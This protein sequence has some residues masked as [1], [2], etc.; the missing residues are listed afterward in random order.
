MAE[1][2]STV[3]DEEVDKNLNVLIEC[4]YAS[5]SV[6]WVFSTAPKLEPTVMSAFTSFAGLGRYV[7][8]GFGHM[9]ELEPPV[10]CTRGVSL[11]SSSADPSQIRHG[12]QQ[13]RYAVPKLLESLKTASREFDWPLIPVI[14]PLLVT[15]APLYVLNSAVTVSTVERAES[16][17]EIGTEHKHLSIYQKAGPELRAVC[18]ISAQAMVAESH[19]PDRQEA[20][21]ELTEELISAVESVTIVS[22]SYL[23]TYLGNLRRVIGKLDVATREQVAREFASLRDADD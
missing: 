12:L 5:P 14:A 18:A 6:A 21:D 4:K 11:S 7:L 16:I 15:N 19:Q 20:V 10:Y 1:I 23:P 2:F 9:E 3:E 8:R 17:S 13:I 22:V